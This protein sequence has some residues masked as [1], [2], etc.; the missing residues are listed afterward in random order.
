MKRTQL[1]L[2]EDVWKAL[3]IHSRQRKT[4]ISE[5]VRQA[6]REKYGS[7]PADRR[8]AMQALVGLWQD[9]EDLAESEQYV[10]RLRKGKRLRRIA[11]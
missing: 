10:R 9:R 3:H 11:S 2:N 6:V 7:S 1:Y 4:S 5:L 8:Q